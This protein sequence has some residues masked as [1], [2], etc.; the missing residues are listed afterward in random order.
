M[1]AS[2]EAISQFCI[3]GR[4]SFQVLY[5]KEIIQL[6]VPTELYR[7]THGRKELLI[8]VSV[9]NEGRIVHITAPNLYS[10]Y[11]HPRQKSVFQ[12]CLVAAAMSSMVQYEY[13][14]RTGEIRATADIL[15]ED[16]D[17]TI[18]QFF[19]ALDLLIHAVESYDTM[20]KTAAGHGRVVI[21]RVQEYKRTGLLSRIITGS[22]LKPTSIEAMAVPSPI[23]PQEDIDTL[24]A[25]IG[26]ENVS[27]GGLPPEN[28]PAGNIMDCPGIENLS[29][30]DCPV[31][32]EDREEEIRTLITFLMRFSYPNALIIGERGVGKTALV[33]KLAAVIG[34]GDVPES[35]KGLKLLRINMKR[36]CGFGA[37]DS[38]LGMVSAYGGD[39]ILVLED[40]HFLNY[41]SDSPQNFLDALDQKQMR[42]VGVCDMDS[43][44][45]EIEGKRDFLQRFQILRVEETDRLLTFKI[46]RR[47]ADELGAHYSIDITD[48]II[49]SAIDLA[50]EFI[51]DRKNPAKVHDLLDS[52]CALAAYMKKPAL[53]HASLAIAVEKLT[54]F[55]VSEKSHQFLQRLGRLEESLGL[56]VLGQ[57]AA[58]RTISNTVRICKRRIDIRPERPDGVF[59][60]IGPS[61][62]GKT[63]LARALN[64][65]LTGNDESL[66]IIDMSEFIEAHTVS[67]FLGSPAGYLGYGDIPPY[68]K[69]LRELSHG[70]LLLDEFEKAHPDIHR[71]FLQVFD[72]GHMTDSAGRQYDL[73]RITIIATANI[74]EKTRGRMGFGGCI[75]VEG[76]AGGHEKLPWRMLH[77]IFPVEL[78][79][80]FDDIILFNEISHDIVVKALYDIIL[81]DINR[82]LQQ[83]YHL[84]LELESGLA[85]KIIE[86]GYSPDFGMRHLQRTFE[87][88]V[89]KPLSGRI[90]DIAGVGDVRTVIA[91]MGVESAIFDIH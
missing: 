90:D 76:A 89:L 31:Q 63:A 16:S 87:D 62:V 46:V 10:Y 74:Y 30:R 4:L 70:V 27:P 13:E 80:R 72:S 39:I 45:C 32:I 23:L 21:P 26:D 9:P 73:S 37:M 44:R 77:S 68:L 61:G 17:L 78:L 28:P 43:F 56:C 36:L 53:D 64:F 35:L 24:L 88:M 2:I 3:T 1:S 20:I 51:K 91:R 33:E 67:K 48:D 11:R 52:A 5:E 12:A 25:A 55:R 41:L 19:S 18:R 7:N 65:S 75:D 69:R 79:N 40:I 22:T 81:R 38:F 60:F 54:G 86:R 85:E 66:V 49:G 14:Q 6:A 50:S 15:L 84:R 29:D 82:N 58:I 83:I 8:L 57:D 47:L 42:V 59:L 34:S 71:L